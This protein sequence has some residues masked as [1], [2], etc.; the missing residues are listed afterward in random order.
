MKKI[1]HFSKN[2]LLDLIPALGGLI[3]KISLVSSFALVWAAELHISTPNFV[4][5]SV[6]LELI[7]GSFITLIIAIFIPNT[8]PAGTL[9]PLIVLIPAMAGFGVHPFILSILVGII[10]IISI[11]TKVFNKLLSLSGDLCKTSLTLMF[12]FSGLILCVQ[13][14]ISFFGNRLVPL[15]LLITTLSI[16]YFLLLFYKKAWFIIPISA[17]ISLVYAWIFGIEI[18]PSLSSINTIKLNPIYWW[19]HIWGVSFGLNLSTILKTFPFAIFVILL[20]TIDTLS[21]QAIINSDIREENKKEDL[22]VNRSFIAVSIRNI[23]GGLLGGSQTGSL[24]RSFLIPLYMMKR[25]MR[26]SAILLGIMGIIVGIT[27]TP[28]KFLSFSPLVWTVLLY[29]IFIPF[30]N[31]GIKNIKLM[32]NIKSRIMIILF[33]VLGVIFNPILA[34]LGAIIYEKINKYKNTMEFDLS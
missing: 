28:I 26:Y 34:W 18:N 17:G 29:G 14:L 12:G 10:G 19:E 7:I 11:K 23:I 3:G 6:R 9:A 5:D 32:K 22:N 15:F 1:I 8:A 27:A 4:F 31:T 2:F 21:V 20:W 25:P 24:W 16:V 30:V 33:T 13:K